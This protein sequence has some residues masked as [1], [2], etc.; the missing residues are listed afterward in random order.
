MILLDSEGFVSEIE[1]KLVKFLEVI[2]RDVAIKKG[3]LANPA[4]TGQG[5]YITES[6]R[7]GVVGDIPMSEIRRKA[8]DI[9]YLGGV[10]EVQVLANSDTYTIGPLDIRFVLKPLYHAGTQEDG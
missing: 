6:A 9:S 8:E 3:V 10:V 2:V 1:K 4:R 5:D 7:G